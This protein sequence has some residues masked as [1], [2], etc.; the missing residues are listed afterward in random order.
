[1]CQEIFVHSMSKTIMA[2]IF[3]IL[4]V[5]SV[6][7]GAYSMVTMPQVE[8]LSAADIHAPGQ[9]TASPLPPLP[10]FIAGVTM[11]RPDISVMIYIGQIFEDYGGSVRFGVTNNDSRPMFLEEISFNWVGGLED[12]QILVNQKI[13]AGETYMIKSLAVSG[14][15]TEGNHEYQIRMRVLQLRNNQWYRVISGTDDWLA[16][17]EHTIEVAQ[18]SGSDA[19]EITSNPKRYFVKLNSLVDFESDAVAQASINATAG[20]GADYDMGKVCAI[21]DWLDVNINY[22]LD[23]GGG[24]TWYSPDETLASL[25]GDCEDYA[26]LLAAMVEHAG[27]TSRVYLTVDHAFAAVYVGNTSDE[28]SNAIAGVQAYYGT[29]VKTHSFAD[30]TGYWMI[31]DPLG[32]L[33]MGG[34]AVGQSPTEYHAG[35][36]NTT[37]NGTETLYAIDVTGVDMNRPLWMDSNIWMGMILVFGFIT[38]GFLV[39]TQSEKPL[40][41]TLCHIC[42]GEIAGDLYVCPHCRTTYHRPCAFS[43]AYCM[44]CGRPIRNQNDNIM[45]I[46]E[47]PKTL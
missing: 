5:I 47:I 20:M 6:A 40:I 32:G 18:L 7:M 42:A 39:A 9:F 43:K 33:H 12:F 2:G 4:L 31:A 35:L 15:A 23:P 8:S 34:L 19:N 41:K 28:L 24:D 30:E 1:M 46:A 37:F 44:T 38:I 13:G 27:G 11:S 45:P 25:K 16:F 14:P 10:D 21:F 26:M 3:S 22:T 29:D 36:W 17:T